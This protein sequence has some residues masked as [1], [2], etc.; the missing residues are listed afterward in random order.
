M[1]LH[2]RPPGRGRHS[3]VSRQ[4]SP[5]FPRAPPD[6]SV[7]EAWEGASEVCA[8]L[9]QASGEAL[10]GGRGNS[11]ARRG[12]CVMVSSEVRSESPRTNLLVVIIFVI[13]NNDE[14]VPKSD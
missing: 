8:P 11:I 14:Q 5:P 12:A 9:L 7:A 2:L 6:G 13:K 4:L 10:G 3:R 1:C